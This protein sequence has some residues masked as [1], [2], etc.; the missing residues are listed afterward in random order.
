MEALITNGIKISVETFYQ[1]NYSRPMDNKF[2]FAYRVTIENIGAET[3]QLMRRHWFIYDSSGVTREVE[4][5]GVIGKQPILAPGESHQYVSWSPLI[6]DIG[7]MTGTFLMKNTDTQ[8]E[9]RVTI[10]D[11]KLI[12]P[13]KMN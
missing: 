5:E 13:Y 3:V 12:T 1:A 8:E 2:V 9:F 6:S 7:K 10:P 4:G 11:F